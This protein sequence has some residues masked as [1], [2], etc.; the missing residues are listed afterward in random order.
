ME[1]Y[2]LPI[3]QNNFLTRCAVALRMLDCPFL[4]ILAVLWGHFDRVLQFLVLY[5]RIFVQ[6]LLNAPYRYVQF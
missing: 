4:P 1:I 5:I 2:L 3:A 6:D